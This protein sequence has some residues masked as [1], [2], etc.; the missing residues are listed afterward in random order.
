[1]LL[2]KETVE[3][4]RLLSSVVCIVEKLS[5]YR[6]HFFLSLSFFSSLANE[7]TF[8]MLK[9]SQ[10]TRVSTLGA[11]SRRLQNKLCENSR[12]PS[13][14]I[15][16]RLCERAFVGNYKVH[17]GERIEKRKRREGKKTSVSVA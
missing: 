8:S 2:Y 14:Q 12:L 13:A 9:N 16:P 4:S 6:C 11:F 7:L 1:M 15:F 10:R 3:T 5:D 17:P